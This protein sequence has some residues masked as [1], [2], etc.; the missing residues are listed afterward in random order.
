MQ[1]LEENMAYLSRHIP[2]P[3]LGMIPYQE[4]ISPVE[5]TRYLDL[6]KLLMN[7]RA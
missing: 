5:A 7:E 6:S 1:C 3:L 2:A 4:K